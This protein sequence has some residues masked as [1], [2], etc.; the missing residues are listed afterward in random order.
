MEILDYVIDIVLLLPHT[1]LN[2]TG[3]IG[4][5]KWSYIIQII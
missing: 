1:N 2:I 5:P 3:D 4:I